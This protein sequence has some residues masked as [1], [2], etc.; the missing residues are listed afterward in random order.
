[1]RFG[2][3]NP[4]V[5][6]GQGAGKLVSALLSG[7]DTQAAAAADQQLSLAK[8][9]FQVERAK[10]T[11]IE[12]QEAQ[13]R[14][15]DR[16]QLGANISQLAPSLGIDPS[17]ASASAGV[18]GSE[19]GNFAQALS[20]L[21]DPIVAQR[22]AELAATNPSLAAQLMASARRTPVQAFR[23]SPSGVI[24]QVTGDVTPTAISEAQVR[25]ANARTGQAGAAANLSSV[26]AKQV[27]PLAASLI[28]QRGRG[29]ATKNAT[30]PN[31]TLNS[32]FKGEPAFVGDEPSVDTAALREFLAFVARKGE[33]PTY[34][35]LNEF[36][37][38]QE[39]E[40]PTGLDTLLDEDADPSQLSDEDLLK[41]LGL[42]P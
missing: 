28:E 22:A 12:R 27:D 2:F 39:L 3:T 31:A 32:F 6:A 13:L 10:K 19:K 21:R 34:A 7:D 36:L 26:R 29:G 42:N 16:Q 20:A 33:G 25:L 4:N 40:A 37:T 35:N 11:G 1:M 23:N 5:A 9:L 17:I 41:R 24:N 8:Q 38:Q 15:G 14:L 30:I 18:V